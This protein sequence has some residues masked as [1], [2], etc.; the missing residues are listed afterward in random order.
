VTAAVI[1]EAKTALTERVES[2]NR[3]A[4]PSKIAKY[5]GV[6][7]EREITYRILDPEW[8]I[9]FHPD[10][11]DKLTRGEIEVY[12]E[13]ASAPRPEFE[14]AMTMHVT[15]R[16]SD[17][18]AAA[19]EETATLRK[20][21]AATGDQPVATL[22]YKDNLGQHEFVITKDQVVIGRGGKS[23]WVDI[24]L[25]APPD[26]SREH[27]RIRRNPASNQFY[28]RDVSQFGTSVDGKRIP[29]SV[30]TDSE[31][32]HL[33]PKRCTIDLAGVVTIEFE[34]AAL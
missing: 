34:A 22:R 31:A 21:A 32:E 10:L 33:L 30:G 5:L 8:S 28:I 12:S 25:E 4:K 11:E 1:S 16:R 23:Y 27:C 9:E 19:P 6:G 18:T 3:D 14:G 2:W 13:L 17:G 26:V 20:P 15:K 29:K 24:R 7:P